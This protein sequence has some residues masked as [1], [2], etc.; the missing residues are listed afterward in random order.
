MKELIKEEDIVYYLTLRLHDK[1]IIFHNKIFAF[2]GIFI[3][4]QLLFEETFLPTGV[5]F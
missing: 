4:V 5:F 2:T 1:I 3:I